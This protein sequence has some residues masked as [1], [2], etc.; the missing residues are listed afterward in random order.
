MSIQLKVVLGVIGG[1]AAVSVLLLLLLLH[2]PL[3][4]NVPAEM[5]PWFAL[6]VFS[7]TVW[8]VLA[9]RAPGGTR[10]EFKIGAGGR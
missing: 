7:V 3:G 6:F 1:A 2:T 9:H 5:A 8:F 10:I 4:V